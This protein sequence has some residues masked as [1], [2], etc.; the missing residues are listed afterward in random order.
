MVTNAPQ[1]KTD[2]TDNP[3]APTD[4]YASPDQVAMG[5]RRWFRAVIGIVLLV[6]LLTC[7]ILGIYRVMEAKS[8]DPQATANS[9]QHA[10]A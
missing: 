8:T 7:V 5:L 10:A 4:P 6:A 1:D 9:T 3:H 2:P